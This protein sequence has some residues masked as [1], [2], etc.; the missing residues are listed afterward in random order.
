MIDIDT[1]VEEK[2]FEKTR[3]KC[4]FKKPFKFEEYN[5]QLR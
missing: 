4:H 3:S 5:I 1:G 2:L